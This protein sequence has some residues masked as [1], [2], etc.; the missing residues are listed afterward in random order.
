VRTVHAPRKTGTIGKA[1]GVEALQK[2][3]GETGKRDMIAA[4]QLTAPTF[5]VEGAAVERV[6]KFR[7][8]GRILSQDDYDV[9]AC[10]RNI[11]R[12]KA[13][14]AAVSKV[15]KREGASKKSFARFYLVIVSTVLQ[16]G[17]DT[18]VITRRMETLLNSLHYR[19]LRHITRRVI[20]CVDVENDVWIRPSLAGVLEEALLLNLRPVMFDIRVR[21]NGLLLR[22]AA[23]R[24]IYHRCLASTHLSIRRPTFWNQPPP[25][26]DMGN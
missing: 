8:L 24:P 17:S 23:R 19:C 18:W 10:D 5:Y 11:Q 12:A 1:P 4:A 16:Y 13:K 22:Y 14:W 3:E 7:Y 15:L 2:R 21:R 6:T 26:Q 9:S 25:G 20:R